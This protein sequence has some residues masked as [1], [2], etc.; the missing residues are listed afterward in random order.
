MQTTEPKGDTAAASPPSFAPV[1]VVVAVI[2]ERFR[3]LSKEERADLIV[4]I[5]AL[6][7]CQSTEDEKYGEIHDAMR[8]LLYPEGMGDVIMGAAGAADRT[9]GLKSRMSWISQKI[10]ELRDKCGFTQ[11]DLAEKSGLPQSHISRLESGVH[12]PSFKT[13]EKLAAALDV[14]VGDI[15]PAN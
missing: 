2:Q 6:A 11:H 15:D 9:D 8:E 7:E 10:K 3:N 1:D 5:E 4:L 12:S 14:E 13:L